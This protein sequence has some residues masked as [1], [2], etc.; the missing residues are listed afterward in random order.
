[1]FLKEEPAL[2][3]HRQPLDDTL[4]LAPHT[5]DAE[6]EAILAS[7]GLTQGQAQSIYTVLTNA[8][9]PWPKVKLANGKEVTITQ[10]AYTHDRESANR[11]DRKAVMDAF[12]GKFK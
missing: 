10:A 9:M 6:G 8:E 4:R 1:A 2:A 11:D 12:F 3:K 5:L 7:F